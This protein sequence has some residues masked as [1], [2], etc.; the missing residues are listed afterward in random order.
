[1]VTFLHISLF[2]LRVLQNHHA[3]F[4]SPYLNLVT[5]KKIF[6]IQK[7]FKSENLDEFYETRIIIN[8]MR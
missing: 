7:T 1:M 4:E 8:V 6:K 2:H 3:I 5:K